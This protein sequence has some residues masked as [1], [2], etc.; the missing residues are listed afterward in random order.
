MVA[1]G[2]FCG[3][4]CCVVGAAAGLATPIPAGAGDFWFDCTEGVAAGAVFTGEDWMGN[5]A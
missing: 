1:V 3:V 5:G 2:D 4:V